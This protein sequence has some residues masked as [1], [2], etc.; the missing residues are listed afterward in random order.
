MDFE[1]AIPGHGKITDKNGM[2]KH[3]A[4]VKNLLTDLKKAAGMDQ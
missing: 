3:L 1:K 2:I 4:Y